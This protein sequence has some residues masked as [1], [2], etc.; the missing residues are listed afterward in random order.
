MAIG[1]LTVVTFLVVDNVWLEIVAQQQ[2][3]IDGFAQSG[4][5]SMR[6]Y[7]NQG[8]IGP[9]VFFTA[10]FGVFGVILS[11]AGGLVGSK[12]PPSTAATAPDGPMS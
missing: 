12:P 5:E 4:A 9:A 2:T 8:L 6:S 3:K 10:V 11:L 7:I 1:A